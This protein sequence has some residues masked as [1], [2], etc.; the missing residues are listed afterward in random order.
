VAV[1][2][3]LSAGGDVTSVDDVIDER[4]SCLP[5]AATD[6]C[7]TTSSGDTASSREPQLPVSD[8]DVKQADSGSDSGDYTAQDRHGLTCNELTLILRLQ[9]DL[10]TMQ[11]QL[12]NLQDAMR[13]ANAT[14]QLLLQGAFNGYK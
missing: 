4:S 8:A 11:L 3:L 7:P 13:T 9:R 14:L 6:C 5:A 1:C 10:A 2:L 12:S